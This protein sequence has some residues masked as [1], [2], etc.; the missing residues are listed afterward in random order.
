MK[1]ILYST[2]CPKCKVLERKLG[3]KKIDFEVNN[4]LDTI[5]EIAAKH[6]FSSAPLFQADDE[7][8]DF[9]T[10]NKFINSITN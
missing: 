3:Q 7:V 9:E 4:D 5:L 8:M 2:D 6:N 10:A 1:F